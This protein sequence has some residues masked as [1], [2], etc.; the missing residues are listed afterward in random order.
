MNNNKQSSHRPDP[1]K[2]GDKN[3]ITPPN[4]L[5]GKKVGGGRFGMILFILMILN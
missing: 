1:N 3:P 2:K 5:F 4:G